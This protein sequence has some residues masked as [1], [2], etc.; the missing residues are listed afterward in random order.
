MGAIRIDLRP[1][2]FSSYLLP[3]ELILKQL[4]MDYHF[5]A[6]GTVTCFVYE[7]TVTQEKFDWT[8]IILQKWFCG[9]KPKFI[10]SKTE[11][12]KVVQNNSFNAD[13]KLP[14]DSK[15]LNHVKFFGFILD[16]KLL[17]SKQISTVTSACYYML[18]KIYSIRDTVFSD[19]LTELERILSFLQLGYCNSH[20]YRLPAVLHDKLQWIMTCASTLVFGLSPGTPTS[21]FIKQLHRFLVQK[22]VFKN[23]LFGH[24]QFIILNEFQGFLAIVSRNDKVTR[25]QYI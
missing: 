14:M 9:A 10:T 5:Y 2:I 16:D 19:V 7:E 8:I 15:F 17:F 21:R 20:Y 6:D 13:L 23:L 12:M 22:R 1:P 25:C 3:L 11:H 18:R 4:P 24:R